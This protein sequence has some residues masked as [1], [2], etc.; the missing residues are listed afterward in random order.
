MTRGQSVS[1]RHP[2]NATELDADGPVDFED[3]RDAVGS[4]HGYAGRTG[5]TLAAGVDGDRRCN[6]ERESWFG[7]PLAR[8]ILSVCAPRTSASQGDGHPFWL[9]V[10]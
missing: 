10:H 7:A 6:V 8:S 4:V 3:S 9:W 1:P 5:P 2:A